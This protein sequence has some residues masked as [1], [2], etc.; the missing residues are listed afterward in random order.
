MGSH[1][2][3]IASLKSFPPAPGT[4]FRTNPLLWNFTFADTWWHGEPDCDQTLTLARSMISSEFQQSHPIQCRAVADEVVVPN[5]HMAMLKHGPGQQRSLA[6]CVAMMAYMTAMAENPHL[7]EDDFTHPLVTKSI[8]SLMAIPTIM[9]TSCGSD[10]IDRMVM[11]TSQNR[12]SKVQQLSS[13][14][15][16][17]MLKPFGRTTEHAVDHY[18]SLPDV[19]AYSG[20]SSL[21]LSID[22]KRLYAID[23]W[24]RKS[25][26]PV[27]DMMTN[28]LKRE[29]W[30]NIMVSDKILCNPWMWVGSAADFPAANASTETPM[31][32]EA[33][34]FIDWTLQ[35]DADGHRTLF[36]RL[37]IDFKMASMLVAVADKKKYRKK[38]E[39]AE[40]LRHA[41]VLLT[42][43]KPWIESQNVSEA[44]AWLEH[45]F[46]SDRH[47]SFVF[48]LLKTKPARFFMSMIP[49]LR[50]VMIAKL[51]GLK[52]ASLA[53]VSKELQKVLEAEWCLMKSQVA[54][55]HALMLQIRAASD[56]LAA[57]Q[58]AWNSNWQAGHRDKAASAMAGMMKKFLPIKQQINNGLHSCN[59]LV[60]DMV[61]Q[62]ATEHSCGAQDVLVL[63]HCDFNTQ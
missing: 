1:D 30:M 37:N 59:L 62:I 63:I 42:Q 11:A 10:L 7:S 16:Y 36:E 34:T 14:G 17:Q 35:M 40:E 51:H 21:E 38:P 25:S 47:D 45:A 56:S 58:R 53:P 8:S 13:W 55:D 33:S 41:M 18:N 19:V 20:D 50:S 5:T 31:L 26:D 15:W 61:N 6:A 57:T 4:E 12:D 52:V 2:A 23:G 44:T 54:E 48:G 24:L 3:L 46:D 32:N 27:R 43:L 28:V 29:S 49:G 60:N 22:A 9:S 39:K